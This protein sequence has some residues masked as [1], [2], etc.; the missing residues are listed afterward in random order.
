MCARYAPMNF[1]AFFSCM[2]KSGETYNSIKR[3]EGSE[4]YFTRAFWTG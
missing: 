4:A 2:Q 3:G 1:A